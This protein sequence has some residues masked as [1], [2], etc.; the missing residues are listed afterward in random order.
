MKKILIVI[1]AWSFAFQ[2]QAQVSS[3]AGAVDFYWRQSQNQNQDPDSVDICLENIF[4]GAQNLDACNQA[5]ADLTQ[6]TLN[7]HRREILFSLL[8]KI[9]LTSRNPRQKNLLAGLKFTH[10][11]LD[12]DI[13]P[14][15]QTQAFIPD[16]EVKAWLKILSKKTEL[17]EAFISLNGQPL[18]AVKDFS[19]PRGTYQ[20]TLLTSSLEP[21]IV[22]GSW[23]DFSAQIKNL[24]PQPEKKN[25]LP[26]APTAPAEQLGDLETPLVPEASGKSSHTWIWVTALVVGA[27]IAAAVSLRGKNVTVTMPGQR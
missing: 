25:W 19:F 27:G 2:S 7:A 20:W 23:D 17:K 1:L 5:I 14:A 24:K 11:E 15:K 18:T 3:S 6:A 12:P 10:P 26:S 16:L 21:L 13:L 8:Q 4:G 22:V 9:P